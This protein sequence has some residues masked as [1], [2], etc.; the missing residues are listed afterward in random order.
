MQEGEMSRF[1]CRVG[2]MYSPDSLMAD[3]TIA[4]E[5]ALWAAIRSLEEQAQLS[6][7]MANR[8]RQ[9]SHSRLVRRFS[10][11]AQASRDDASVLRGLLE[12]TGDEILEV[13]LEQ[14]GTEQSARGTQ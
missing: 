9:H 14:T 7:R 2:H 5:R 6:E 1:R 10:E 12:R 4:T 8:S 11:K 13:P 3:Q